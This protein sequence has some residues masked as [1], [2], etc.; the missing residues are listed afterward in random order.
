MRGLEAERKKKFRE[1]Q[2][3]LRVQ[4]SIKQADDQKAELEAR[5]KRQSKPVGKI[6]MARS[7]KPSVK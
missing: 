3:A 6:R 4:L 2:I 7:Q 1:E 5:A